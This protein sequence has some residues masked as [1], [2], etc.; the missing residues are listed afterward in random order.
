MDC[1]VHLSAVLLAVLLLEACADDAPTAPAEENAPVL[2]MMSDDTTHV[3]VEPH[4]LTLDTIGVTD[5]LTATVIDADGDTIDDAS[6][7]WESADTTIAKVDTAGVVTSVE[8]GKTKG[9][10]DVRFGDR[11]RHGGG[12]QAAHRPRDPGDLLRGDGG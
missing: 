7:T 10:G 2:A 6:V 4:W 5:T 1:T 8:F 12:R 9:D 3:V 11:V